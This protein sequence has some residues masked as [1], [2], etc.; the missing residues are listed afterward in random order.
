MSSLKLFLTIF[1]FAPGKFLFQYLQFSFNSNTIRTLK[2]DT[3]LFFLGKKLERNS[4][5]LWKLKY[6]GLEL[7]EILWQRTQKYKN[8]QKLSNFCFS[9]TLTWFHPC[10][11]ADQKLIL[12]NN[13]SCLHPS[14]FFREFFNSGFIR[15]TAGILDSASL[16]C[17]VF[18]RLAAK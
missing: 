8:S 13:T 6:S 10:F 14:L 3:T 5:H 7:D 9:S 1:V 2:K 4:V 18:I 15:Q 17:H 16:K 11:W 12:C